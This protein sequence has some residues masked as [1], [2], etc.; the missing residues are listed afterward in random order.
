LLLIADV[1]KT[2]S[3][4]T[5]GE[6]HPCPFS[7]TAHLTF[8]VV[9]HVSTTFAD[10]ATP[11]MECPRNPGQV[12]SGDGIAAPTLSERLTSASAVNDLLCMSAFPESK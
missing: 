7:G 6:D 4:H 2:V 5:M 12:F 3:P 10:T 11:L 9:V 8:S 1:T